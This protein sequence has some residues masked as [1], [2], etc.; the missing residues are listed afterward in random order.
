[1]LPHISTN[2]KRYPYYNDAFEAKGQDEI[3]SYLTF[4]YFLPLK[5]YSL[6]RQP[7]KQEQIEEMRLR[8]FIG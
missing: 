2:L 3:K 1:M 8:I 7:E 6:T 5:Y 4:I